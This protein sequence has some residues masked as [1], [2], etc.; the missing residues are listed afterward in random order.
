MDN[1]RRALL[2]DSGDKAKYIYKAGWTAFQNATIAR[3]E[4]YCLFKSDYLKI[5]T[6]GN[7]SNEKLA[8][9]KA[10]FTPYKKL[11]ISVKRGPSSFVSVED[12]LICVGW[13]NSSGFY[14]ETYTNVTSTSY[15]TNA[16]FDISNA[17]GDKYIHLRWKAS[18]N[19]GLF[20]YDIHFE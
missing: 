9:L 3:G 2:A 6:D 10:D 16:V 12:G 17:A 20:V 18:G 7:S 8:V 19:S 15:L 13:G 1:R 4:S 5:G 11:F 14:Y